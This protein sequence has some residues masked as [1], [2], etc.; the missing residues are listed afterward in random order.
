MPEDVPRTTLA[1]VV[2][3]TAGG[4][5]GAAAT[6]L[7][8]LMGRWDLTERLGHGE[9]LPEK[10]RP[11]WL[12]AAS[13]GEISTLRPLAAEVWRRVEGIDWGL[14]TLTRTGAQAATGHFPDP[15]FRR[16]LPLDV[17]PSTDRFLDAV[18]P[19]AALF[20]ET[21]I[22]PRLM[23][24]LAR[25]RVPVCI[26]SA[27][28]S[29][30]SMRGYRAFGGL[31]RRV[32][33]SLD[34][35]AA[36]SDDDRD[37][38]LELGADPGRTVALGNLKL[39]D[40]GEGQ[41]VLDEE[42]EQRLSRLKAGRSLVVWGSLRPGEE[43]IAASVI[44]ATARETE[45]LW[46]LAP[47]H[48]SEFD[49][50]TEASTAA[51]FRTARWSTSPDAETEPADLLIL[52]TLGDLRAFYAHADVAVVGG[53]FGEYG[54]HNLMEPARAGVPVL[55]G[56]DTGEW[57]EDTARLLECGGGVRVREAVELGAALLQLLRDPAKRSEMG[58]AARKAANAGRGANR[59][60]VEALLATGFFEGVTRST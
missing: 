8:P 4:A 17:W 16:L 23:L 3:N 40:I 21:E 29:E 33:G 52:D 48:P 12:H 2:Y 15:V 60:I 49:R 43:K 51:G 57:P 26:A 13:V 28:L 25:R 41:T 53:S 1:E 37:R 58:G 45:A 30:S 10:V 20:V 14:T 35:I 47:R 22:W 59:R 36:R 11:L 24:S 9:P 18:H 56:P 19:G 7:R 34:F 50:V 44:Q 38:F 42:S 55:F 5:L 6:L 39:D 54:G 31:F 46:V 27:R 32:V